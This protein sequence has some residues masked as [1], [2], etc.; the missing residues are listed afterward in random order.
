MIFLTTSGKTL[1]TPSRLYTTVITAGLGSCKWC[2]YWT[3]QWVGEL[4]AA[5]QGHW[6][7]T[8]VEL[9]VNTYMRWPR[10]NPLLSINAY[11]T[12]TNRDTPHLEDIT[13]IPDAGVS[14]KCGKSQLFCLP[15]AM[16]SALNEQTKYVG[17]WLKELLASIWEVWLHGNKYR[18]GLKI[19]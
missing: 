10:P 4:R 19:I 16:Q 1:W 12:V 5:R 18:G 17:V 14:L 6:T 7:Q 8:G 2:M 3:E 15:Q 9:Q 11:W 13:C